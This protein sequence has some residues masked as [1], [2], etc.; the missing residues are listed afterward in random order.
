MKLKNLSLAFGVIVIL[1][2]FKSV[3]QKK[4]TDWLQKGID[5]A[6]FQLNLLASTIDNLHP[7]SAFFP[8]TI[9]KDNKLRLSGAHDWTSGFFPGELWY[10]YELS[11]NNHLAVEARKFTEKLAQIQYY[12]G[13]HDV[14]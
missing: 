1:C 12:K 13:I 4:D 6:Q 10:A 7:D 9:T 5:R 11:E 8:R 14:G 2:G 3:P